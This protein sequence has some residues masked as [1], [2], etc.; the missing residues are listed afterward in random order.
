MRIIVQKFGGTSVATPEGRQAVV[1]RVKQAVD[2]G[3]ATVVVVSAMGRQGDPYATDTLIQMAQSASPDLAPRDMDLLLSCGEI[4]S[5]V[6]MA[7]TL[8]AAGI[9]AVA[10]T[11]GQAGIQTDNNYGNAQIV[12]VDPAAG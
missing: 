8:T 10:L 9:P 3:Y 1:R 11:G 2:D 12:K 7:A 6:L 5:S 4:I